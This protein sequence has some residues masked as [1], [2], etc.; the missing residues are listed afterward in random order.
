[1]NPE[2]LQNIFYSG[3]PSATSWDALDELFIGIDRGAVVY[4]STPVAAKDVYSATREDI[5]TIDGLGPQTKAHMALKRV[6]VEYLS[7]TYHV[8]TLT[9]TYFAGLHPDV[10]S[11]DYQYII[12]CGTTDPS[13]VTIF[14]D[15]PRVTWVGNIPYPFADETHLMLHLFARGREYES[16][17]QKSVLRNRKIFERFHRR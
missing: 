5:V 13:C 16:W 2:E 7:K 6:A 12:E 3:F 14:L 15:D 17:R 8:R 9:E 11:A 4:R 10:R 1:M